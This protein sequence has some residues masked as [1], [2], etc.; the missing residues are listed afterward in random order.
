MDS[1]TVS[2][3]IPAVE[4]GVV[5]AALNPAVESLSFTPIAIT[6]CRPRHLFSGIHFWRLL[7]L[8]ANADDPTYLAVGG[9]LDALVA[10]LDEPDLDDRLHMSLSRLEF[11]SQAG[12]YADLIDDRR[13]FAAALAC[14]EPDEKADRLV[15]ILDTFVDPCFRGHRFGAAMLSELRSALD[16]TTSVFIGRGD[17]EL[18]ADL[19]VYLKDRLGVVTMDD[20]LLI[21]PKAAVS[22]SSSDIIAQ[23]RAAG[24]INVDATCLRARWA[25]EDATLFAVSDGRDGD[26]ADDLSGAELQTVLDAEAEDATRVALEA[27]D[28]SAGTVE[29]EIVTVLRFLTCTPDENGHYATVFAQAAD[30][31]E[32]HKE[33]AVVGTNWKTEVCDSGSGEHLALE[34]TVRRR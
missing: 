11:P 4:L 7:F 22:Q 19:V 26:E 2:D 27:S 24:Y 30:Y 12:Y 34:I 8:V 23:S 25:D 29:S 32:A 1:E 15:L 10:D 6:V 18:P 31:L 17:E 33:V 5:A 16:S 21:L 20:G 13:Q 28:Y 14:A 9:H 3:E